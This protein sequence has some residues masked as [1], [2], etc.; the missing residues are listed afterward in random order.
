MSH[1]QQFANTLNK[2]SYN[3]IYTDIAQTQVLVT[4]KIYFEVFALEFSHLHTASHAE[5]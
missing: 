5:V 1:T 4:T 3:Y 2:S